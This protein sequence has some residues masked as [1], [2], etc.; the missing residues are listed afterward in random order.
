MAYASWSVVFGEQPSAAK[1]NILGTND[2]SF[3]NGTGIAASAITPEK[4]LTGTGT[5]WPWTSFTPTLTNI[6]LGNGT[7]VG[8]YK[9][10]GK[11][12]TYYVSFTYGSTSSVGS[13]A[14]FAL[15]ATTYAVTQRT[16]IGRATYFD[17]SGT[18]SYM[19]DV[20]QNSTTTGLF[21]IPQVSGALVINTTT[22]ST[23]PFTWAT[24]DNILVLGSYEAA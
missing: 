11:N 2:A 13:G 12:I 21:V 23:N 3:N 6:T 7:L 16:P 24:G 1:W 9:Q 19:G 8:R 10:I 20:I 22:S 4:L 5:T 17:T 15:P 18:A 14:T